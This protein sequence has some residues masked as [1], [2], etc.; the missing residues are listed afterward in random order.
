MMDRERHFSFYQNRQ[1]E[2]FP[3]HEGADEDN[4]NCLFCYCPL[5]AL[6]KMCGGNYSYT[7]NGFKDCTNCSFPHRKG[8]YEKV[9][10]RYEDIVE[11]IGYIDES[12]G[13]GL[14]D[15]KRNRQR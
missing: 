12:Y 6:G 4:F 7:E 9:L 14:I 2:Y 11:L 15:V 3:C 10:E 1:C 13:K 8:N 5:Y